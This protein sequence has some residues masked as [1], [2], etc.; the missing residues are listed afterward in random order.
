MADTIPASEFTR[1]FGRYL[2]AMSRHQGPVKLTVDLMRADTV[3]ENARS[4]TKSPK[5]TIWWSLP[6]E[7]RAYIFLPLTRPPLSGG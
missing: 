4:S 5:S 1:N 7:M 6:L 3:E 2:R